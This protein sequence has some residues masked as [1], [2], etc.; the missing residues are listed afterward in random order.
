MSEI[1]RCKRDIEDIRDQLRREHTK[2]IEDKRTRYTIYTPCSKKT[3]PPN[4]GSKLV[5]S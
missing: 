4:F 3:K 5:K 1:E 2:M